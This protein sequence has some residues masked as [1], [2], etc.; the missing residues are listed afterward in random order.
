MSASPAPAPAS[1]GTLGL[2]A[3]PSL[4][5]QEQAALLEQLTGG[6][7]GAGLWWVSGYAAGL[8]RSQ[9]LPAS[10]PAAVPAMEAQAAA[11]LTI[12]YGSQTGNARRLAEQLAQQVEAAGLGARLVRADAYATR[13]LKNERHLAIVI[14]TQ[15]DGDPPDDAR[16][17][18]EFIAGKRAPQLPDLRYAVLALGD[19]SYPQFCA[20]GRR[21]DERLAELGAQ[22]WFARG[23]ADLDIDTVATPWLASALAA[24]KE[25]LKPQAPLATVTPLRPLASAVSLYTRDNPFHAELLVNQRITGRG[26]E[27]VASNKDIRHFELSLAGSGLHYEPGD[28]LG[29]WPV[30]PPRLV[31][32][33]LAT[34][35]LDGAQAVTHGAQTLPLREWLSHRRELTRLSRPFVATHAAHAQSAVLNALLAPDRA[36]DFTKLLAENQVIDL[37]LAHPAAWSGEEL[38]AALRPLAPRLYSIASSTRAVGAEEVH[39]TVAHIEYEA[40]G[41]H[42]DERLRWGAASSFLARTAEGGKVPVFIEPNERFRVPKDGTRDVILVGPGTGVA[43]FRGFVQERAATGASGRNWLFFGNP[44][45]RSDFLYQLEWQDALKRGELHRLDLAFSRDQAHKV[46]VQDRLREH[47]AEVFAWLEGGA[48]VYVCGDATRMAKDVHAALLQ[49]IAT[50]G[51][52]SADDANDYL[53]DLQAQG[54]YSRD[55]Y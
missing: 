28:A 7:D 48:H 2:V 19:S 53:N 24:A 47:G 26:S 52:R 45:A 49:I 51:G 41:G 54:R 30:N 22:R 16:G 31:E 25:A 40:A 3:P 55:V 36:A 50:H 27:K 18:V 43:P 5:S 10:R 44:H 9:S 6:L 33:V 35:E 38:V 34:L 37:L 14:S 46:Y 42:T 4:L 13:E 32:A 23:E 17:F 20:I 29:V 12:V 1:T 11:R 8:A 21:L 15:G 39:L